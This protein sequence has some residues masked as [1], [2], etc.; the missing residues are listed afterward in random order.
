LQALLTQ[1]AGAP[2]EMES[3]LITFYAKNK[4]ML[5]ELNKEQVDAFQTG[6]M[7]YVAEHD[8]SLFKMLRNTKELGEEV[9]LRIT[10]LVTEFLKQIR[11]EHAEEDD[12]EVG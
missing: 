1:A 2:V 7:P 10:E 6:L 5:K 8:T 4:G 11:V 12:V 3:Q 9:E